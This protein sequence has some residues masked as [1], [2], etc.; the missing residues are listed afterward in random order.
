MIAT[1]FAIFIG[2]FVTILTLVCFAYVLAYLQDVDR[3]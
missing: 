2:G 3:N 1:L